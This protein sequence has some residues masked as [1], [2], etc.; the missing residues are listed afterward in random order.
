M[1]LNL[2]FGTINQLYGKEN[3]SEIV[4]ILNENWFWG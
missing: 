1:S 4:V 3:G 2:E